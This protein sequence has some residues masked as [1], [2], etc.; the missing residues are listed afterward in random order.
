MFQTEFLGHLHPLIV[1]LPIGILL[2]AFLMMLFQKFSKVDMESAISLALLLGAISAIAA[3][4]PGYIL[5][6]SGDYDADLVFNH[7]WAGIATALLSLLAYF[8]K[9]FRWIFAS[10]TIIALVF[11]GHFGGVLTHGDNFLFP[12]KHEKP[13]QIIRK[14]DSISRQINISDTVKTSN[15]ANIRKTFIYQDKIRPILKNKCYNC[16][17]AIKKKNGLR[18][19]TEDFIR[20]GGKNGKILTVGN[21]EKST[22]FAHLILPEDDDKHMPPKGK[23]QLTIKE[24]EAIHFWI[25]KGASFVEETETVAV[26]AY[27]SIPVL[28]VAKN[29]IIPSAA[30]TVDL[31]PKTEIQNN[32]TKPL[33]KNIEAAN[34]IVLEKLKKQQIGIANVGEGSNFI[35]ANFVNVKNYKSALLNELEGIENQLL[36]LRLS[37]QPIQD[38]DIK[39]LA[40]FK[41]LTHLNIENTAI[42]DGA[43]RYL[44]NIPNLEQVNLYGTN[45]TDTGLES[46]T[47]CLNLKVV[48]LW[49][50]KATPAGIVQLKKALPNLKIETGGFQFAKPDS[51]QLK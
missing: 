29:G 50:T 42:T 31:S 14:S 47:K 5:A 40:A 12:I 33:A 2:F 19:D 27:S 26:S 51:I 21:P 11:A 39:K 41:N 38:E 22:L 10:A 34:P 37:N 28:S 20:K 45:I 30:P 3:C 15:L 16:H 43:L 4:V 25:K 13:E 6:Q 18:L 1:H 8:S 49:K 23:P 36:M 9:Q 48:Y 17:S 32:E 24:I 46:L 44:S 35:S 7:Q